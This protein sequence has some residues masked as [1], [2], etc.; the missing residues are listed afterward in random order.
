MKLEQEDGLLVMPNKVIWIPDKSSDLQLRICIIAHTSTAGHR[1]SDATASAIHR[2]FSGVPSMRTLPLSS[3]GCIHRISTLGG[4]RA[5]RPFG[6]NVHGT[7]VND[8]LQFDFFKI[9]PGTDGMKYIFMCCD[10]FSSCWNFPFANANSAS[11]PE[12][13]GG[14][15]QVATWP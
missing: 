1:G 6:P 15:C 7:S 3:S 12:P 13:H 5:P 4:K 11:Q 9:G 10:D 14:F 2:K 8:I